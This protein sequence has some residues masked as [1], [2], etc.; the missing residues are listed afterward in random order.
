[1]NKLDLITHYA[2]ATGTS[3]TM[4]TDQVNAVINSI[5]ECA[6]EE[7][8]LC[9]SDIGKFNVAERKARVCRHPKTGEMIE[10][11]ARKVFKFKPSKKLNDSLD[12]F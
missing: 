7:G 11:P 12:N 8:G 1:M 9:I 6:R 4:A 10:V 5:F 2:E 3:K